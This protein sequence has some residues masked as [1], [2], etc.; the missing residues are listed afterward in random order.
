MGL[1]IDGTKS[2]AIGIR[3]EIMAN[4]TIQIEAAL[5]TS[6]DAKAFSINK[7]NRY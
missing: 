7:V 5:I 2:L 6:V 1:V 3:L 4:L